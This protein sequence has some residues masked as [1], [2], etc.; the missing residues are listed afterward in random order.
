MKTLLAALLLVCPLAAAPVPAEDK[1]KI[2][3][4]AF[5]VHNGHFE[6]NTSGLKGDSSYLVFTDRP[7]FDK[8]FGIARV[9]GKQNFVPK[10]AFEKRMVVAVIKRG[11]A[12]VRYKDEQVTA[13]GK[14]LTVRY[15]A[16]KGPAGSA[17]FHSPL[18][19]S[20]PRDKYTSVTF[21][22]N[23]KKAETLK[24]GK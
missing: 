1:A 5:D 19:V 11:N 4:I 8:V 14:A 23:G 13:D 18:I 2:N 15:T 9:I 21:V 24:I 10:G 6:K 3:K 16:T 12:L 20:L 17:R 22:E 7:S